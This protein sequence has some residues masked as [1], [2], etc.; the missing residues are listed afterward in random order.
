MNL[1]RWL[2]RVG[3]WLTRGYRHEFEVVQSFTARSAISNEE[4]EFRPGQRLICDAPDAPTVT[5]ETGGAFFF[6]DRS[7]FEA[8]CKAIQPTTMGP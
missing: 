1:Q 2:T 3:R 4:R 7:V 6:A 8:N 5:L